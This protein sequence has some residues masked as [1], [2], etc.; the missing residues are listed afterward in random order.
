VDHAL[1]PLLQDGDVEVDEQPQPKAGELQIGHHLCFVDWQQLFD[2]LQLHD[3]PAVYDN[4][5]PVSAVEELS[6]VVDWERPL[7]LERDES[8]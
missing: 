2:R 6:L 7:P 3:D 8:L 5:E 1:D 4:V